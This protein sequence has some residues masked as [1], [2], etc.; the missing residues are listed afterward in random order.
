MLHVTPKFIS[1]LDPGFQPIVLWNRAYE[2]RVSTTENAVD[3]VLALERGH[4]A[5]SVQKMRILPHEGEENQALNARYVERMAKLMLWMRGGFKLT[6]AGST[7]MANLLREA[8]SDGGVRDF[9]FH[10]VAKMMARPLEVVDCPLDEAPTA[11]DPSSPLG[12]N[13]DG[14]RIGFDLGGSDRKAAAVKDGEVVFSEEIAW[15]PYFETDPDYQLN[16]IRDSLRR[17]AEHLPRVDAIGGSAAGVYVDNEVRA[18]SLFRGIPPELYETRVR[19][20]FLDIQQEWGGIPFEVINDGEVTA[21]AGS[22]SLGKNAVLGVAMGTSEAAGYVDEHGHITSWLN[23]LA[24]VPVD[25]QEN[26]P[27][28][29]WS[30]D[31]GC[32]VNYFSQQGIARLAVP[33]G[34]EFPKGMELPERLIEVQTAM[35]D[36]SDSPEARKRRAAARSV[37]EATGIA[38]GYSIAHYADHYEIGHLL[39]LGR[40]TSGEGGDIIIEKANEVLANEF[41]ELAARITL[42][43]PNEKD[44]RHGQAIAA[45]S[46]PSLSQN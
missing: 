33:A 2:N 19:R 10:W 15:S 23:E 32:G 18:A 12:R 21:L 5:V 14:Y 22:M 24:F 7:D 29:E 9:D 11:N 4:G 34:F 40:V 36:S 20:M 30:G 44:K 35:V 16:G 13:L 39:I 25:M 41:P 43:T 46:L 6:V 37:Y 38:F 26:A 3:V 1:P 27:V 31:R 45:A 28:D 42:C 8:Y 17:A